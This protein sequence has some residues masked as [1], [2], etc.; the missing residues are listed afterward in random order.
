MGIEKQAIK[1]LEQYIDDLAHNISQM[2][3]KLADYKRERSKAFE[4]LHKRKWK[5]AGE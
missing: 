2:E 5:G 3:R 1:A 4:E